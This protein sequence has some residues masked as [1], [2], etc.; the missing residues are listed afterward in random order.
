[1]SN[2][3]LTFSFNTG[4]EVRTV[5]VTYQNYK[6]YMNQQE[7]GLSTTLPKMYLVSSS[8]E[9]IIVSSE[10]EITDI[11]ESDSNVNAD[12]TKKFDRSNFMIVE[13]LDDTENFQKAIQE[14]VYYFATYG[15]PDGEDEPRF[16]TLEWENLGAGSISEVY[17]KT[18]DAKAQAE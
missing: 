2:Q 15:T 14:G 6:N 3:K 7:E 10:D 12:G 13:D 16:K 8:G 17:D 9:K 1:M 18:D 5:D 11:V 4:E